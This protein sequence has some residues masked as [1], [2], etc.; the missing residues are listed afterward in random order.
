LVGAVSVLRWWQEA[1]VDTLVAEAPF[2]WLAPAKRE[3]VAPSRV[4]DA[5]ASQPC[6]APERRKVAARDIPDTLPAFQEW[7]STGELPLAVPGAMRVGASGNP[8]AGLMVLIDMPSPEDIE[9]ARLLSGEPGDLFDRMM[10]A[11][12][13]NRESLYLASLTPV[14]TPTGR[15]DEAA[16]AE[17]RTIALRHIALAAPKA[18]LLFGDACAKVL[19]GASVAQARGKSHQL[20][21]TAGKIST[22]VTI[23]PEKLV[24]QPGLKKYAWDDLQM[25]REELQP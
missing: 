4:S 21:T 23:R 15:F 22:F 9:S 11:I 3:D 7:L 17:L 5:S 16:A 20:E 6:G 19:L 2:D 24:K 13:R 8:A 25:L 14:R 10:T 12:G 1:G 18:L